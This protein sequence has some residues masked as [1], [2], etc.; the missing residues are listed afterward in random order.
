MWAKQC[1]SVLR[2][3]QGQKKEKHKAYKVKAFSKHPKQSWGK[4]N[5]SL[6]NWFRGKVY[7]A[8]QFPTYDMHSVTK[9]DVLSVSKPSVNFSPVTLFPAFSTHGPV[10]LTEA[11]EGKQFGEH[12]GMSAHPGVLRFCSHRE[13]KS[14]SDRRLTAPHP[15]PAHSRVTTLTVSLGNSVP[16]PHTFR[17]RVEDANCNTS[18]AQELGSQKILTC[19]G[20]ISGFK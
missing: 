17:K 20:Q 19:L 5:P 9:V 2:K 8:L 10:R 16:S 13:G 3:T 4:S 18:L 1:E 7:I 12:R 11:E 6:L 15:T 14:W